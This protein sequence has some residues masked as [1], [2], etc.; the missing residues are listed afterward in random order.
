MIRVNVVAEGQSEMGFAKNLLNRF[1]AGS[2]LIDSRCVLTSKNPKTNY[3]YR[4]G[5]LKYQHAKKDI[6]LW[7]REDTTAYVTTM[8][9]FFRLPSDFPGYRDAMSCQDHRNSIRILEESLKADIML[10]MNFQ[11]S[12]CR[13]IPYIQL[14]EFEALLFT[15]INVLKY[16]YLEPEDIT[17]INQLY[18]ETKEIPPEEINHG[19]ETAPSKRL[20]HAVNY[21]KGETA[22]EL[23]DV[24]G[25]QKIRKKCPHFSE[26]LGTLQSLPE[27]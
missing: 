16:D 22:W 6:L 18:M 5:L 24:I 7:L 12:E 4:G 9:D 10:E 20:L 27:L 13:F 15:D 21:Q 11:N 17:K 14:H 2:P 23:L 8:F 25:I 26:W 19:A 3:E 1:F